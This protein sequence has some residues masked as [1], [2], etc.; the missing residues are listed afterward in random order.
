MLDW[1]TIERAYVIDPGSRTVAVLR[2]NL[3]PETG[4]YRQ[5]ILAMIALDGPQPNWRDLD[6]MG[7]VEY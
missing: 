3:E 4:R 1:M 2:A 5:R 6:R 7:G